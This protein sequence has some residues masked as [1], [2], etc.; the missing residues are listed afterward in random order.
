MSWSDEDPF[1][2]GWG[3]QPPPLL[4]RPAV[5]G[6][7]TVIVVFTFVLLTLMSTC[8]PRTVPIEPTTTTVERIT[9]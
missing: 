8:A 5:R 4:R 7:I 3:D 2:S 6:A 1:D 9:T